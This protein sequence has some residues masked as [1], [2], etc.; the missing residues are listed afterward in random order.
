MLWKSG[1]TPMYQSMW[2]APA[3]RK[4]AAGPYIGTICFPSTPTW[5]RMRR[6]H[7]WQELR[8]PTLQLQCHLYIVS[9][10]MQDC[11]GWLHQVQQVTQPRVVQISLLHL[12]VAPIKP[13]TN[14]HGGTRILVCKA[15]TRPP[16][17]WDAWAGLH[18][19]SSLYNAFWGS[20]V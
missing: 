15:G 1:P 8:I 2:Y 9:L 11:L 13:G 14:F 20:T 10:L 18:A 6:M 4:G 5:H 16:N 17:L 19:I 7:P 12:D 3:M